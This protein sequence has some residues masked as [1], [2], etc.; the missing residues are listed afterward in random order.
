M[1]ENKD[2]YKNTLVTLSYEELQ[3][4]AFEGVRRR[5]YDQLHR[6]KENFVGNSRVWDRD[7]LGA[8][9][10]RVVYKFLG[11][12]W[13]PTSY[14][15]KPDDVHGGVQVKFSDTGYLYVTAKNLDPKKVFVLVSSG[16]DIFTYLVVGAIF[17]A[18]A[19]SLGELRRFPGDPPDWAGNYWVSASN[20]KDPNAFKNWFLEKLGR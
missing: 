15:F 8:I 4:A 5:C 13:D 20:L 9:G 1:D 2:I 7:I 10:E 3:A 11:L 18:D 14:G 6:K 16:P 19:P 17:G 12:S